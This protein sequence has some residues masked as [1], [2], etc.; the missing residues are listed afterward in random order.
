ME[1]QSRY[2]Y[3]ID[4]NNKKLLFNGLT[5]SGFCRSIVE[6]DK[7]LDML[8]D[9]KTFKETFPNDFDR[10][11]KLGFII[12]E[13][14]D[15]VAYIRFMNK[16]RVFDNQ[17]YHL[18][19][20]PTLSC[21]FR[22]WYCYEDHSS[23]KMSNKIVRRIKKHIKYKVEVEKISS[24]MIGWFGGEPLLCFD[25]VVYPISIYAK[26]ICKK[27]NIPYSC[28]ITTN[29]YLINEEMLPRLRK[30]ELFNYQITLDGNREM[31][32]SIRNVLGKPS[33]DK[34][35]G[36]IN[37][38]CNHIGNVHIHLR[39]NYDADTFKDENVF[40]ILDEFPSSIRKKITI[41]TQQVWQSKDEVLNN[42]QIF[43]DFIK[44][45]KKESY[46]VICGGELRIRTFYTCYASRI[47][48]ANINYDGKVYKCTAR[49]Y[50]ADNSV[51]ILDN[52]GI[53]QW[54]KDKL[55][56]M[57]SILPIEN[58]NCLGCRYLPLCNGSCVQNFIE[59]GASCSY[60]NKEEFFI[61]EI[62]RFYSNRE[63]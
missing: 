9:M 1:K 58:K 23:G 53:I 26:N 35:I 2:N 50:T 38:L 32:N 15:E 48:Y 4:Y 36:N 7:L 60:K 31:H 33:Y 61:N 6:Y 18:I 27:N 25:S 51:G 19:I 47:N 17:N 29:G 12:D 20:N 11:K 39:I 30:I 57:Y 8:K 22:C 41:N 28:N 5:G 52:N 45:A 42:K 37:L 59:N 40:S 16:K 13:S 46:N 10:L 55:S 21:N 43:C 63:K 49:N 24:L 3:F 56:K 44:T 62:K 34:I 14:F 54:Q